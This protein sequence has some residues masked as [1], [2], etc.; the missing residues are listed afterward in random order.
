M[1]AIRPDLFHHFQGATC[2]ISLERVQNPVFTT[3]DEAPLRADLMDRI[4]Q[5][6][7]RERKKTGEY[8]RWYTERGIEFSPTMDAL[9]ISTAVRAK[10]GPEA[11]E[12][13]RLLTEEGLFHRDGLHLYDREN[14]DRAFQTKKECPICKNN[15]GEIAFSKAYFCYV[16]YQDRDYYLK[17]A[18]LYREFQ[19][20]KMKNFCRRVISHITLSNLEIDL[21]FG[22]I[23]SVIVYSVLITTRLQ[24]IG[25]RILKPQIALAGFLEKLC[26]ACGILRWIV[27]DSPVKVSFFEFQ[28]TTFLQICGDYLPN[29]FHPYLLKILNLD[30]L[31]VQIY[32]RLSEA[33]RI[34]I[35]EIFYPVFALHRFLLEKI[36]QVNS[37]PAPDCAYISAGCTLLNGL[38]LVHFYFNHPWT[39]PLNQLS[40]FSFKYIHFISRIFLIWNLLSYTIQTLGSSI[41]VLPHSEDRSWQWVKI[42]EW[43]QFL[44]TQHPFV[45]ALCTIGESILYLRKQRFTYQQHFVV[46]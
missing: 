27:H 46:R 11:S 7:F 23:T 33:R 14:L 19:F 45:L 22:V 18:S 15:T 13:C 34:Q 17:D 38:S 31:L 8:P 39:N 32:S 4:C 16:K 10:I 36:N 41:F 40:N 25:D 42:V 12:S 35:R 26:H 20:A 1:A 30:I 5:E 6:I 24:F 29:L 28:C 43:N 2:G 21:R 37:L 3:C 44:R 9:K